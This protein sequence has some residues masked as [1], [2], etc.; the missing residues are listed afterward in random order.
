MPQ[1]KIVYRK[2]AS[3]IPYVGNARLHSDDQVAQIARSI[4]EFGFVNPILVDSRNVII[5][6]HGRLLAAEG[7]G[8][9][10][11]PVIQ[12]S[13]LSERQV[14]ALVLADNKIAQNATWDVV[15]LSQELQTLVELE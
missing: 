13:G 12:L 10:D 1:L 11:V 3:L 4:R 15:K 2:T 14:Q 7:L 5:A 9:E 8:L 6:G